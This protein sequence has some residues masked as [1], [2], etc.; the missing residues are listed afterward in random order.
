MFVSSSPTFSVV[1]I[2]LAATL[3]A[4]FPSYHAIGGA[5]LRGFNTG[6][7]PISRS[8]LSRMTGSNDQF[9][10]IC[11]DIAAANL[12]TTMAIPN[13][14]SVHE[15][16]PQC[17][18][19]IRSQ[20]SCG[21][22]W[23]FS[24]TGVFAQRLCVQSGNVMQSFQLS[25]QK[26]ISCTSDICYDTMTGNK[27]STASSTCKCSLGCD[28]GYPDGAFKYMTDESITLDYCVPYSSKDG[29][30]G[31]T[32]SGVADDI[33]SCDVSFNKTFSGT[34]CFYHNSNNIPSIQ[35]D[36]MQNGPVSATFQ[37]YEDFYTY[38]SGVYTC[39]TGET[40]VGYHA[41][42][43]VGWGTE[44][45]TD[46]WLVENSWSGDWGDSGYFKIA[47]GVDECG[48]ETRVVTTGVDATNVM[49]SE[50]VYSSAVAT[51]NS[52]LVTTLLSLLAAVVMLL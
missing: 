19:V 42:I 23:T 28:G 29:T 30:D 43:I 7:L 25:P 51:S 6:R 31:N 49:L 35:R 9:L 34:G 20:G 24:T 37:V 11:Q 17:K 16:Y 14:Y 13:S 21:S 5:S 50:S 8:E 41:V 27:C 47:R 26:L 22:C 52:F 33:A 48:I 39:P 2:V 15:A 3:A 38:G 18:P 1:V 36:L 32:C 12:D 10:G 40:I 45:N 4:T 46:Y 44:D